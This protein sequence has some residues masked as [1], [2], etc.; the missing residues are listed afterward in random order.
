MELALGINEESKEISEGQRIV[1]AEA[2]PK[3]PVH[4]AAISLDPEVSRWDRFW[5]WFFTEIFWTGRVILASCNR[6]YWDNGFGRA[7]SLA[8][9]TLLSVVP[10]TTL[11]FGFLASFAASQKYIPEL[12]LFIFKQFAPPGKGVE[13]VINDLAR[14]SAQMPTV[15]VIVIFFVVLTSILLLNS[16]EYAVNEV[17]QVYEARS[18]SHRVAIFCAILVIAPVL[19]V[20]GYYTFKIQLST[21]LLEIGTPLYLTEMYNYLF[22]V[23]IDYVA[24]FSL[25]YLV[26]KAPVRFSSATFGAV[27]AS[28]MFGL[29][30]LSF[31][32]YLARFDSFQTYSEIYGGTVAV[33]PFFLFWLYLSWAI[34]LVGAEACFQAQ[35][36]PKK[37][38]LWKR[39][40]L[41]VG[42]GK[43]VLAVQALVV[44]A[45]AY[46]E[47]RQ[48]PTELELTD[49]LGCS[50]VVLRSALNALAIAGIIT[51]EEGGEQRLA[52][53]KAPDR[54]SLEQIRECIFGDMGAMHFPD[55]MAKLFESF[56]V[57]SSRENMS[58]ADLMKR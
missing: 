28:M 54:I 40:I 31:A 42:D 36:L 29:A 13:T 21:Y 3:P 20:S 5:A 52:L 39:K 17:W 34:V 50:A 48:P 49:R 26:P 11:A 14:F 33:I 43:M 27:L 8:Y 6:F 46:V 10:V 1:E 9:T 45:R 47:G 18:I 25:Y 24:F 7:A 58:L 53:M 37:G 55:E 12:Q 16:V 23:L 4:D 32:E 41:S 56:R 57:G 19:A 2:P 15:N 35:Y 38:K 30:K 51:R 44:V 22:G